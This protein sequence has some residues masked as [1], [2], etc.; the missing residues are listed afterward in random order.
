MG[1]SRALN[2][3]HMGD[4]VLINAGDGVFTGARALHIAPI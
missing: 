1:E 2:I 4:V 3:P